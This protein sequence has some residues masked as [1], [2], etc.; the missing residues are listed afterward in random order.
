MD[1]WSKSALGWVSPIVIT[2]RGA[3]YTLGPQ[4]QSST[5]FKIT[6]NF[7]PGEYLLVENRQ[8]VCIYDSRMGG[9][10]RGGLAIWHID[11]NQGSW[12]TEGYPGQGGWPDNGNHYRVALLQADQLYELEKGINRGNSGDLY[13]VGDTLGPSI[14]SAGPYPNSDSYAYGKVV[15][16]T[17]I[18][19]SNITS[20]GNNMSFVFTLGAF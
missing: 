9:S 12:T 17:G 20:V 8:K 13:H 1:A 14:S 4:C 5:V 11:E 15:S 19:I 6:T 3:P 16:A 2:P 7:P 10:W 18:Y